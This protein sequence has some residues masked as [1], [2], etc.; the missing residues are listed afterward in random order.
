MSKID[1]TEDHVRFILNNFIKN[2]DLCVSETGHSLSSIKLMLQN[3]GATYGL[4]NFSKGNPMYAKIADE[5]RIN[6]KVFGKEM[7]KE[8]F[9]MRFG[10]LK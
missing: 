5:Y 1:Y 3:I 2:E 4:L 10:I 6:N 8:A 7:S 9:C